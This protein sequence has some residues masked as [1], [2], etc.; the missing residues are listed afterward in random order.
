[1]PTSQNSTLSQSC[2]IIQCPC[3]YT[4]GFNLTRHCAHSACIDHSLIPTIKD[5]AVY[6]VSLHVCIC[7][8]ILLRHADCYNIMLFMLFE[9]WLLKVLNISVPH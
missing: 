3:F 9:P 6:F 2:H 1:M 4:T 5:V 7:L 8:R